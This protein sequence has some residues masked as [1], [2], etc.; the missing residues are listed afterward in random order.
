MALPMRKEERV[1]LK[2]IGRPNEV[3]KKKTTALVIRASRTCNSETGG[4][5]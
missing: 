4:I 2:E 1:P 5:L 3:K